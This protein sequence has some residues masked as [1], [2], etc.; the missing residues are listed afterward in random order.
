MKKPLL[1]SGSIQFLKNLLNNN[2]LS[3]DYIYG[4]PMPVVSDYTECTCSIQEWD[5][6]NW[7][8]DVLVHKLQEAELTL[9]YKRVFEDAKLF[10]QG[11]LET[12]PIVE[13]LNEL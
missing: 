5:S 7:E 2:P 11:K 13:L 12:H 8:R 1:S 4:Q 10:E 6:L 3:V 9:R